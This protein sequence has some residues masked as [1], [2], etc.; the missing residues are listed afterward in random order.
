M[1][2]YQSRGHKRTGDSGIDH[3]G[4]LSVTTILIRNPSCRPALEALSAVDSIAWHV[5]GEARPELGLVWLLLLLLGLGRA[6]LLLLL[7]LAVDHS[8]VVSHHDTTAAIRNLFF[9]C[10]GLYDCIRGHGVTVVAC[11]GPAWKK[12]K[13]GILD[14]SKHQ[15]DP[16]SR[17][18]P[19]ITFS[20]GE[21][22]RRKFN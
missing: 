1:M 14:R 20:L 3:G 18:R 22:E 9:H 21:T 2:S 6:L 13:K 4:L 16:E 7:M 5:A 8:V 19:M 17:C 15:N 12:K 10:R 11:F